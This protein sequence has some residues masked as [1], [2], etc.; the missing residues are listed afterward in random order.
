MNEEPPSRTEN[1]SVIKP[2]LPVGTLQDFNQLN[3]NLGSDPN[4]QE[5]VEVWLFYAFI[6]FL[7]KLT[8]FFLYTH[9][10]IEQLYVF[11]AYGTILLIT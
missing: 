7:P 1:F 2:D 5:I 11:Y 10:S 6:F 9:I 4:F 3:E 8:A